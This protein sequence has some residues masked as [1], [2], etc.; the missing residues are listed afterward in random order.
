MSKAE[1]KNRLSTTLQNME[2]LTQQL[3]ETKDYSQQAE[4]YFLLNEL[5]IEQTESTDENSSYSNHQTR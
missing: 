2:K 1:L 3:R 5:I 4:L